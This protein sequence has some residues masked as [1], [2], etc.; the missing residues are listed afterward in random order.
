MKIFSILCVALLVGAA[1]LLAQ[2]P[3]WNTLAKENTHLVNL[4]MSWDYGLT[5][6]LGYGYKFGKRMPIIAMAQ[7]SI[8]FGNRVFDDFKTKLGG[9]A[10]LWKN[11]YFF[12]SASLYG[13]ARR[14]ENANVRLFNFGA[15]V[16]GN[17]GFYKNAWYVGGEIGWD[18]AIVT[19]FKHSHAF[20]ESFP[21]VQDGWYA[22]VSGGNVYYGVI[23]GYSYRQSDFSFSIGLVT[24]DSF[25]SK[26]FVPYYF[27]L[28]WNQRF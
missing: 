12:T 6:G 17:A 8:P 14:Y 28:G 3:N 1:P 5:T 18:K 16:A 19:S 23:T 4:A 13:I 26:P 15:E 22:P 7:F 20:K 10:L 27:K 9:Q 25:E 2:E 24:T 21:S 11:N